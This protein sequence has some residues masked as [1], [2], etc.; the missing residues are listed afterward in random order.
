M[1]EMVLPEH[2]KKVAMFVA[3]ADEPP[4]LLHSSM[5]LQYRKRVQQLYESFQGDEDEKRIAAAASSAEGKP[6][7]QRRV[8]RC[9]GQPPATRYRKPTLVKPSAP[10]RARLSFARGLQHLG[11]P[12]GVLLRGNLP[13]RSSDALDGCLGAI[14]VA[15]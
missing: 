9:A 8:R 2:R 4:P 6:P 3:E 12:A 11:P 7:G 15:A 1:P 10:V 5:A 13:V 14:S